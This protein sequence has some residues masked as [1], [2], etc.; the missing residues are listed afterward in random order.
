MAYKCQKSELHSHKR[1]KSI[2]VPEGINIKDTAMLAGI[3]VD[4]PCGGQGKCGKCKVT[5]TRRATSPNS[6]E[7]KFISQKDMDKGVR[8]ACQ[9]KIF[10]DMTISVPK[11]IRVDRKKM[12]ISATPVS[13]IRS[14]SSAKSVSVRQCGGKDFRLAIDIGTTTIVGVLVDMVSQKTLSVSAVSN[15]Q[16]VH[17]ADVISRIN[18]SINDEKGTKPLQNEVVC[19]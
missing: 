9:M 6:I 12:F 1:K 13:R 3:I 16:F 19:F 18:Y 17:G 10:G 11:K 5:V 14:T 8:L 7:Q 15:P 2:D 4:A